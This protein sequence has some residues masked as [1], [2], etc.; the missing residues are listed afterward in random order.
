MRQ[1]NLR[2]SAPVRNTASE[3]MVALPFAKAYPAEQP[4]F[5]QQK[6]SERG[7]KN[8]LKDMGPEQS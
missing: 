6:N 8:I 3:E 4:L 7:S 2:T 1:F 5:K